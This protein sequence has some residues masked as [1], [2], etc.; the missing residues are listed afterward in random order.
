LTHAHQLN[1]AGK[2]NCGSCSLCC[3]V[4]GVPEIKED[5]E[6]CRHARPGKGGC[7]IYARRP[8]RCA[9]FHCQWLIDPRFQDY[10]KPDKCR[11]IVDTRAE[12][13]VKVVSFVVDPDYPLRWRQEPWFSDIKTIALA[14]LEG[15]QGMRWTTIVLIKGEKI[16]VGK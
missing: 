13:G 15:R 4:M 7:A 2:R 14:G 11:I 1:P 16:I 3:K 10:W 6:W 5:H 12:A 8:E 9:D